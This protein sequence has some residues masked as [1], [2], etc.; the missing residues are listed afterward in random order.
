MR[1]ALF[2]FVLAIFCVV[3]AFRYFR[4][5]VPSFADASEDL[6]GNIADFRQPLPH[7]VLPASDGEWVNLES[8][9]GKV[10]LI[11]FWTTWCPV[12]RDEMPDLIR[13]QRRFE[14][15]GFTVVALAVDDEGEESVS[16][17]VRNESFSIGG[18]STKINFPVLLGSGESAGKLGFDGGLPASVLVNRDGQEVNLIRG[19][20]HV[21]E[22]S[23]L[24]ERLL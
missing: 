16:A 15:S 2:F 3:L 14:S 20:V 4:R 8:Y 5:D 21:E 12:C 6:T 7:T 18:S 11:N 9:R 19:P 23:R 24:I 17:Y 13:L 1:K 22:V 10:V